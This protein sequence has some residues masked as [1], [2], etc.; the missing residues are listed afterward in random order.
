M[1]ERLRRWGAPLSTWIF[2]ERLRVP[3]P[4][5]RATCFDPLG[6]IIVILGPGRGAKSQTARFRSGGDHAGRSQSP[7]LTS[8]RTW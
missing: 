6:T 8:Q 3:F 1:I 4:R 2:F 7:H 5:F